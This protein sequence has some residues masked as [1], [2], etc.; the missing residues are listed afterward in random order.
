[1]ADPAYNYVPG[2]GTSRDR[3]RLLIPDRIRKGKQ[4]PAV[5]DDNEINDL[6]VEYGTILSAAAGACEIIAMDEAKRQLSVN[7]S[8]GMSIS[9]NGA[10][11][12]LQRAKQLRD[13]EKAIAGPWEFI[14]SVSYEIDQFGRD[15]SHYVG[16][17][18][19][20]SNLDGC[21]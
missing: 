17:A 13:A 19:L 9:R 20:D 2:S 7:I 4:P 11:L 15:H 10:S 5:F 18:M 12:W 3:I 8:S 6:F 1:M 16:N 21:E 14:D